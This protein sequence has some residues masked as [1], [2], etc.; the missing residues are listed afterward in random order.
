M[1]YNDSG[2]LKE[3]TE[4][5]SRK[6][7]FQKETLRSFL[8]C[9]MTV[10][11]SLPSLEVVRSEFRDVLFQDSTLF[12]LAWRFQDGN[13][14]LACMLIPQRSGKFFAFMVRNTSIIALTS[15]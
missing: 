14:F 13:Y 10:L 9:Q 15:R 2:R 7:L 1:L 6:Q 12:L 11:R 5:L 4:A 3:A 8:I